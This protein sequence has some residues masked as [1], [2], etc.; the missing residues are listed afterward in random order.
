MTDILTTAKECGAYDKYARGTLDCIEFSPR[1]LA[2][3]VE[4]IQADQ[5]ERDA[6]LLERHASIISG[7]H[8]SDGDYRLLM[9][10]AAT[11]R[12]QPDQETASSPFGSQRWATNAG[13]KGRGSAP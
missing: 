1:A 12:S 7:P 10:C 3:F 11:I 9:Q 13:D 5:K 4:R 2:A 8:E 6:A